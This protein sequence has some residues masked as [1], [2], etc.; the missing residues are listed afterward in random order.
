MQLEETLNNFMSKTAK[1]KV[2]VIIPLYGYWKEIEENPL[3]LETLKVTMDRILSSVHQTYV[4]FVGCEDR[5][6]NDI[7]NYLLTYMAGGNAQGVHVDG[8]ADYATYIR[9]GLSVAQE[10]TESAYF[11]TVNPWTLIQ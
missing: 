5:M 1:S 11:L 2:A 8:N 6:T 9:E 3:N 4:F 7:K 10:T